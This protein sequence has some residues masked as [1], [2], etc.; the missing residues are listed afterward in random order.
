M[1]SRFHPAPLKAMARMRFRQM[2]AVDRA[3]YCDVVDQHALIAHSR[4]QAW[5]IEGDTL[6]I[7]DDGRA[8]ADQQFFALEAWRN[9]LADA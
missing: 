9:A 6:R 3:A 5:I 8:T 1:A 4:G 2:T 7:V